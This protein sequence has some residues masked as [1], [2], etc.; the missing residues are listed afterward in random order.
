M[1]GNDSQPTRMYS[2]GAKVPVE[3][4]ALVSNQMRLAHKYRNM[5]VEI[6]R[7][8]RQMVDEALRKL[9]PDLLKTEEAITV[10]E[11]N[12]EK[13]KFTLNQARSRA[14]KR[15]SPKELTQAY[16]DAKKELKRLRKIR[17]ELRTALFQA[18]EWKASEREVEAKIHTKAIRARSENGLY[19]GTYLFIEQSM[20]SARKGAPPQFVNWRGDG[21]LAVQIQK[22]ISPEKLFGMN[23]KRICIDPVS[24]DAWKP[25]GRKLR[26]T[27]LHFRIGSDASRAPVWAVIPFV[28]HRPIPE[29]AQVKWVHLLRK[30]IGTHEEWGV[31]IVLSRATGWAR[32]DVAKDGAV[33][34]DVGWR[35][36]ADGS[37][38][39]AYW[40]ASDGK[41][42]EVLL[43]P[44][45]ME[46]MQKVRDIQSIRDQ[47]FDVA[48]DSLA[49]WL[50]NNEAPEWL[51]ER[52]ANL[53]LWKSKQ[54]LCSVIYH[55]EVTNEKE[56]LKSWRRG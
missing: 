9:S 11:E 25:G 3:N 35:M 18:K 30:R 8:R 44:R 12:L 34:V 47:R 31:R 43:S 10:A 50:K 36:K 53:S 19:W 40:S 27:R 21:H 13:S 26:R 32:H 38:R 42:G 49:A 6:E 17:K 55:P 48:R 5:L 54:R 23:D 51:K 1:F 41:E 16:T 15:V 14:R 56:H 22:G 28:L 4:A 39:T 45:W 33:G 7:E 52:L 29:D 20:A 24:N 2:F 37:L 46:G